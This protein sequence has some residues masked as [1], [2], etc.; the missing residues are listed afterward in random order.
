MFAGGNLDLRKGRDGR[1]A[2]SKHGGSKGG[3]P[4]E[5]ST[6]GSGNGD[7]MRHHAIHET[8]SGYSSTHTAADGST[9]DADHGSYDEAKAH[10][11]AKF[12]DQD[13]GRDTDDDIEPMQKGEDCDLS[14]AYSKD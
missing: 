5:D 1:T 2:D 14:G 8:E 7:G 11:D 9:E 3:T 4:L 12:S 13:M 6:G 10:L